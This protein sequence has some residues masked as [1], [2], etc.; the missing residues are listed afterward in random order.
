MIFSSKNACTSKTP[1]G[2]SVALGIMANV[3]HCGHT[4]EV[5]GTGGQHGLGNGGW[6]NFQSKDGVVFRDLNILIQYLLLR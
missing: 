1:K 3:I 4:E 2:T 6:K 5:D